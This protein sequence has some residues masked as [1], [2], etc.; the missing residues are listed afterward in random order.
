MVVLFDT[1]SVYLLFVIFFEA[2]IK[3]ATGVFAFLN[4]E[5]TVDFEV[6]FGDESTDLTFAFGHNHQRRRLDA[7]RCRHIE[8]AVT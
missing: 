2:L 4:F 5:I 1:V 7:A 8:A 3:P 6:R